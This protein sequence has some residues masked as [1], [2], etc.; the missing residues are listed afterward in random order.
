[1]I[2]IWKVFTRTYCLWGHRA[3]Q[4]EQ[5]REGSSAIAAK[6]MDERIEEMES[7]AIE[8]VVPYWRQ[9]GELN[10]RPRAEYRPPAI[11]AN[12]LRADGVG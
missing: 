11:L 9:P 7:D 10:S 12:A 1:L 6:L 3:S 5:P 4:Y 8:L 2:Y